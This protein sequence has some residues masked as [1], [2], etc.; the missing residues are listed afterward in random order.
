[1]AT[2]DANKGRR[3][4]EPDHDRQP[5]AGA[6][7]PEI[8]V[9][10][11]EDEVLVLDLDEN[12]EGTV[13]G[14]VRGTYGGPPVDDHDEF[15]ELGARWD[16]EEL[17]QA[18]APSNRRAWVAAAAA[19]GAVVAVFALGGGDEAPSDSTDV[20]QRGSATNA[21]R[22][23]NDEVRTQADGTEPTAA[24]DS[25]ANADG[26]LAQESAD[27]FEST[28]Q[29]E[30]SFEELAADA[31]FGPEGSANG[32]SARDSRAAFPRER[33]EGTVSIADQVVLPAPLPNLQMVDADV[34]HDVWTEEEPPVAGVAHASF[35][36]TPF[37]GDVRVHTNGNEHFDGELVGVGAGRLVLGTAKGSLT[38]F[39]AQVRGLERIVEAGEGNGALVAGTTGRHVRVRAPGG[40]LRGEVVREQGDSITLLLDSGGRITVERRDLLSAESESTIR[41]AE[42]LASR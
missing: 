13:S 33:R 38:L 2:N 34:M 42:S 40:W 11:L 8:D 17:E 16:G 9:H 5:T 10:A 39:G 26:D 29:R 1:M 15:S 25:T 3:Q 6:E 27:D 37:V 23:A 36:Q 28:P 21:S 12:G 4:G 14:G 22:P 24:L 30:P 19:A 35:V 32:Q 7:L 41:L 18:P 20:A 31:E